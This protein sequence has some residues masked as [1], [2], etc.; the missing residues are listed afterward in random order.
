M[1]QPFHAG[2][3]TNFFSLSLPPFHPTHSALSSLLTTATTYFPSLATLDLTRLGSLIAIASVLPALWR[4]LHSAWHDTYSWLRQ[5]LVAS[6][7]IPGRDP[8][9]KNVVHWLLAHVIEPRA[10][11]RFY[12]AR[13]E[14]RL[15]R[16]DEA[17]SAK[18]TRRSVQYLPHF[19]V[20]WF[21]HG[22]RVFVVQ[23][24]MESFNASMCDPGYD[25]VGGEELRISCVGRSVEPIRA[26][27]GA[28]REWADRQ[29]QFFVVV[30]S[31]DRYGISWQPKSRKPIRL[32][33]TVHFDEDAKRDL[34]ADI[35]KYLDPET[36]KRY[37]SRSMP[38]RRG[39]F[40]RCGRPKC[41][42]YHEDVLTADQAIYSTALRAPA[43]PP[44][45]Q[46]SPVS[47]AST[48]TR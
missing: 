17:A 40:S 20:L 48:S 10:N 9:N 11:T 21:V 45:P 32:L 44:Y 29:T 26:L 22:G 7:T 2:G 39:E 1:A 13:T 34:L 33:E 43:N 47:S 28:C 6:V 5:F 4:V 38:Y 19:E 23:R 37:Q 14:L 46:L 12:T 36:Q 30:Y 24:S 3:A 16:G 41:K 31:R 15:G 27:V 35:R 18:K 8:L 42:C 25:G